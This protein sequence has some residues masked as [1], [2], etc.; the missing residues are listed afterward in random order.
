MNRGEVKDQHYKLATHYEK[1]GDQAAARRHFAQAYY[2]AGH[3]AFWGEKLDEA[4]VAF[5]KAVEYDADFAHA[6]YY[7]GATRRREIVGAASDG[8]FRGRAR[9]ADW[10]SGRSTSPR[11]IESDLSQRLASGGGRESRRTNVSGPKSLS[12]K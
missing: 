2:A 11:R 3:G 4:R 12:G 6:W 5:E 8:E 10:K 1:A 9:C 7:L